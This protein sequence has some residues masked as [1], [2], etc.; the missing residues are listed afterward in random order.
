[1]A[2]GAHEAL[3]HAEHSH[4]AAHEGHGFTTIVAMSMAIIAALLAVVT[5]LSHRAHNDTV[6]FQARSNVNHTKSSDQWAF[7]QAKKI[8]KSEYEAYCKLL[9]VVA[10]DDKAADAEKLIGEWQGQIKKYDSDGKDELKD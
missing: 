6:V 8:R 3:E 10:R 4:H 7:Y 5:L 1:M 9:A 2:G